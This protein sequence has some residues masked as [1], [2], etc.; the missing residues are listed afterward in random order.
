V[1]D[2]EDMSSAGAPMTSPEGQVFG[3]PVVEGHGGGAGP[4]YLAKTLEAELQAI[5]EPRRPSKLRAWAAGG[6]TLDFLTSHQN[7]GIHVALHDSTDT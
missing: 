6:A 4:A 3:A 5:I 1:L 7:I 2:N